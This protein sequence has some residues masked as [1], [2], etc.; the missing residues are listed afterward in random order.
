MS[1]NESDRKPLVNLRVGEEQKIRWKN[2]VENNPVYTSLSD[3]IRKAVE[4]EITEASEEA[5]KGARVVDEV[6]PELRSISED[7]EQLQKDV[8]WLRSQ[9]EHDVEE[10]AHRLFEMLEPVSASGDDESARQ[11][12]TIAGSN[13][14]TVNALASRLDTTP[15]R[16]QEAIEFLK[17]QHMPIVKFDVRGETHWFKEE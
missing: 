15:A 4:K 8:S 12:G 5:N 14:Q 9:K 16:V 10:L 6:R 3:L 17:S 7:I 1:E 13:P 2:H 11:M